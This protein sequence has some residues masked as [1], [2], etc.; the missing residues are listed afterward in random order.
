MSNS[1]RTAILNLFPKTRNDRTITAQ[2]IS[3]TC[4][5]EFGMTF[6]FPF[7]N[8]TSQTLY[9]DFCQTFG[10]PHYIGRIH[11]FI[12]RNHNH[13]FCAIF[14]SHV[15][16]L[17]GTGY[18]DKDSLARIF[19]HQRYMFVS[20]GMKDDLRMIKI[21]HHTYTLFHTHVTDH[22][23]KIYI[24]IIFLKFKTDIV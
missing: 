11:G 12:C 6:H 19:F 22:R 4:R 9:I 17:S 23:N 8:S 1:D 3:E 15:S 14:H 2:Y 20:G 24:W 16:Y 5:D 18:I 10:A 7:T 21:K 13:F